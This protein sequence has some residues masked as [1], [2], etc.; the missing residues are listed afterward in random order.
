MVWVHDILPVACPVGRVSLSVGPAIMPQQGCL[1]ASR[2]LTAMQQIA[3]AFGMALAVLLFFHGVQVYTPHAAHY[4]DA[5]LQVLPLF[6]ALLLMAGVYTLRL[7]AVI[8][9]PS[10]WPRSSTSALACQ[11]GG[12]TE[13]T[14]STDRRLERKAGE[15]GGCLH[16]NVCTAEIGNQAHCSTDR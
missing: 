3:A 10:P 6:L 5:Y 4:A 7:A 13:V 8:P 16:G 12:Q 9:L 2:L 15:R 11:P 1:P 14:D